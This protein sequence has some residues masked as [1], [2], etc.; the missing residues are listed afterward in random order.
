[1]FVFI[2]T[3]IF[4]LILWF[5]ATVL[6][7]NRSYAA[8]GCFLLIKCIGVFRGALAP[9]PPF[10]VRNFFRRFITNKLKIYEFI[11]C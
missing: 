2:Y 8:G 10:G 9:G 1:M 4:W 7:K 5:W 11:L 6:A 3:Y